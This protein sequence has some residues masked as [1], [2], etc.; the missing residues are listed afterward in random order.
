MAEINAMEC[1]RCGKRMDV[2]KGPRI[3]VAYVGDN[4]VAPFRLNGKLT[5]RLDFCSVTCLKLWF[6]GVIDPWAP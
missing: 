2:Q 3:D 1:D 4:Q 6:D 5:A